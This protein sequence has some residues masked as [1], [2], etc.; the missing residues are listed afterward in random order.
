LITSAIIIFFSFRTEL[1]Q[2]IP[3]LQTEG[4]S[5]LVQ[6]CIEQ[7]GK[8]I[9]YDVG[10][11]GGYLFPP[12]FST[13]SGIPYYYSENE[14][15]MPSKEEVENEISFY[16]NEML[17]FCTRNFVDFKD[18]EIEQK[19][20]KTE[21]RIEDEKV[22]LNVNY[23]ITITKGESTSTIEDFKAE[24]SIRFGIVY[25]SV[26]EF[27]Q[28]QL[29]SE[30]ICLSCLLN[31]SL[32]NDLYVDLMDYDDETVLF[33]FIDENSKINNESLVWIFANKYKI[34]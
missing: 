31:I 25:D 15:Y 26:E 27:M 6:E 12:E 20:I 9:I 28:E 17:F 22:I 23:P 7:E 24:I 32:E 21:T 11:N 4:V 2:D 10:Y 29:T 14:N 30:G 13:E 33:I 3:T 34:I 8:K 1:V 5:L 18:L 19:E 16:L